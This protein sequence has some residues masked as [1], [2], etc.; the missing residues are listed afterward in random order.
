MSGTGD[1][2]SAIKYLS[3]A[4]TI[5]PQF[6]SAIC[7][8]GHCYERIGRYPEALSTFDKVLRID[9]S[10]AEAE[11]NKIRVQKKIWHAE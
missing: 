2:E 5:A 3:E 10:H 1:H 8:M 6:T 11:V 7:E 9:P 4:V